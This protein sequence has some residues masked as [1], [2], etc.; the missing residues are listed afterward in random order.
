MLIA[1]KP[2]IAM[3]GKPMISDFFFL[4]KKKRMSCSVN[5]TNSSHDLIKL[6]H[7]SVCDNGKNCGT[8]SLL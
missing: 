4:K 3:I 2:M 7:N 6:L 5:A 1:P 8:C